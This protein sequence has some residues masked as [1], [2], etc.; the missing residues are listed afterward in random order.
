MNERIIRLHRTFWK[1]FIFYFKVLEI[2][3]FLPLYS[4]Y[5]LHSRCLFEASFLFVVSNSEKMILLYVRIGFL[6]SFLVLHQAIRQYGTDFAMIQ[7]LFPNRS[8]QQ[9][10]AKFKNKQ[11]KHPLQIADALVHRS[12]GFLFIFLLHSQLPS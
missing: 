12:K 6:F 8:R 1:N 2:S 9:V 10:K 11:R 7:V 3:C 5:H 4:S